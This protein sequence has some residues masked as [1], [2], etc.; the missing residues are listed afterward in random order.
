MLWV[1]I[2][3]STYA[4]CLVGVFGPRMGTD[5]FLTAWRI[6]VTLRQNAGFPKVSIHRFGSFVCC[7]RHI[8]AHF[9]ANPDVLLLHKPSMPYDVLALLFLGGVW[10]AGAGDFTAFEDRT[11]HMVLE[12]IKSHVKN[13]GVG[14]SSKASLRCD[15]PALKAEK[16]GLRFWSFNASCAFRSPRTCIFTSRGLNVLHFECLGFLLPLT[17]G[18]L[19]ASPRQAPRDMAC[20]SLTE[21]IWLGPLALFKRPLMWVLGVRGIIAVE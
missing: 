21:Y 17:V 2:G 15:I 3:K 8:S 10:A 11:S 12:V 1:F 9:K 13:R 16:S 5:S 19:R 7:L 18:L 6:Q 20:N 4:T 14:Y